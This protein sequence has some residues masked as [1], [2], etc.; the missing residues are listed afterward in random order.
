MNNS[1]L[2]MES[3]S[4]EM[5]QPLDNTELFRNKETELIQIIEAIEKIAESREWAILKEKLFDGVVAGLLRQRDTE[6]EKKPLNGPLIYS[7]NGQL[8]WAKKYSDFASLSNIYKVELQ[9][10]RTKINATRE[11]R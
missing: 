3:V 10:V 5:E 6:V 4:L 2:A 1:F 8:A 7:I 11:T 9:N